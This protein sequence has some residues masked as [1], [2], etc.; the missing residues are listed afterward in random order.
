MNYKVKNN[1]LYK[2]L[3]YFN[4]SK[5]TLKKF[6]QLGLS[7][8]KDV[9]DYVGNNLNNLYKFGLKTAWEI[10]D[11]LDHN[12][13][14]KKIINISNKDS[15]IDFPKKL[16]MKYNK[17]LI[18]D[19]FKNSLIS[20]RTRNCLKKENIINL[21]DLIALGP[22]YIQNNIFGL[23]KKCLKE[24]NRIINSDDLLN[25]T[26]QKKKENKELKKRFEK[27]A[28]YLNLKQ[29]KNIGLLSKRNY[30]ALSAAGIKNLSSILKYDLE[31]M[32]FIKNFGRKCLEEIKKI[33]SNPDEINNLYKDYFINGNTNQKE[34]LLINK[35]Q[36]ERI[37]KCK[38]FYE[39]YKKYGTL[40]AVGNK[41][42]L[43]RERVRQI[44]RAGEALGLYKLKNKK[45]Y[46]IE[47]LNEIQTEELIN[48]LKK[49]MSIKKLSEYYELPSEIIR[50][51]FKK[52]NI[53]S[54]KIINESKKEEIKNK[55]LKMVNELGH[56]P[57]TTEFQ[58]NQR[59]LYSRICR[60]W[61]TINIF[62]S[63]N[64]YPIINKG[65]PNFYVDALEKVILLRKKKKEEKLNEIYN[66]ISENSYADKNKIVFNLNIKSST[67][68]L[69]LK[70][71]LDSKKIIKIKKGNKNLYRVS[72]QTN[73]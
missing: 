55:Y 61:G 71:L 63:E 43:S 46:Q 59:A 65:N 2:K 29:L 68:Y 1:I 27:K 36:I 4:F 39:E 30:N 54:K 19:L 66:F 53:D 28:L 12:D 37:N 51:R 50:D 52:N 17:I 69:Y 15:Q 31:N 56:H 57:T 73:T 58:N 40:A 60:H 45:D 41:Y 42:N 13:D 67:A 25:K 10:R 26:I 34:S 22:D 64:G 62:R 49:L 11:I 23:G 6:K 14:L 3:K 44:I 21:K 5:K 9:L 48:N 8:L 70:H 18:E 24:I 20:V 16:P 7:T 35:R 47:K 72:K 33:R 32:K 38:L